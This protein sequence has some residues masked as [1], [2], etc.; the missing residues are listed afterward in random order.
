MDEVVA[1]PKYACPSCGAEARW[2]P[3]KSELVCPYCNTVSPVKLADDH[4]EVEEHDLLEALSK[5]TADQSGWQAGRVAVKCQSCQAVSVFEPE[6]VGQRC[7]FCGSSQLLPA[8]QARGVRPESLLPFKIDE[9]AARDLLKKWLGSRWF[10]PNWLVSQALTDT[11]HGLYIPYWTFDAQVA[12]DWTAESGYYYYETETYT[13]SEGNHHTRQVQ[14]TRWEPSAGHVDHFFDDELVPATLGVQEE[15]LRKIEPYPTKELVPYDDG[16][17]AGWVV[18]Q[19]QIDLASAA[20]RSRMRMEAQMEAYCRAEVPG[21]TCRNLEVSADFSGQTFK[22][23]LTPLWM[24]TFTCGSRVFP[25]AVNGFTGSVAG[26]YPL[27]WAKILLAAAAA[28]V[29]ILVLIV[30]FGQR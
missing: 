19:Y 29:I 30:V 13:D 26:K 16:Y 17:L 14:K 11:V 18:E 24:L 5:I 9:P 15:L 3:A 23:I 21:D 1:K 2:N 6:R 8:E 4:E 25:A 7:A 22:H 27:S 12:A 28:I 20:Q 10:A